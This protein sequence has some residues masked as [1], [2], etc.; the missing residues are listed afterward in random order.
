MH[1][2]CRGTWFV[3]CSC[4]VSHVVNQCYVIQLAFLCCIILF[5]SLALVLVVSLVFFIRNWIKISHLWRIYASLDMHW[6]NTP[7]C[8]IWC[9]DDGG[10]TDVPMRVNMEEREWDRGSQMATDGSYIGTAE[11]SPDTY[12]LEVTLSAQVHL[13]VSILVLLWCMVTSSN[14]NHF[15]VTGPLCGEF[16][17]RRGPPLK[18]SG[19]E[20]WCFFWPAPEQTVK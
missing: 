10:T 2:H 4:Q 11:V 12:W 16:T 1:N 6:V 5:I 3:A 20:L 15:H 13:K 14:G 9:R 7:D 18:A 17:G 8:N 19:A